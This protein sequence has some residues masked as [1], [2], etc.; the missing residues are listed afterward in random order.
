MNKVKQALNSTN[1]VR[2][3]HDLDTNLLPDKTI[4]VY[5]VAKVQHSAQT[6]SLGTESSLTLMEQSQAAF[7]ANRQ[8]RKAR[9]QLAFI[10]LG[11]S[12]SAGAMWHYST[13]SLQ[14]LA[15]TPPLPAP[16]SV[17]V[18]EDSTVAS[19]V[20]LDVA[21]T[22]LEN[23]VIVPATVQREPNLEPPAYSLSQTTNPSLLSTREIQDPVAIK[24]SA[25]NAE[26]PTPA[27]K[28]LSHKQ[29][30]APNPVVTK[31][32]SPPT[33]AKSMEESAT[34]EPLTAL[35]DATDPPEKNLALAP[36]NQ[37]PEPDAPSEAAIL[38]EEKHANITPV[39]GIP[40]I[41]VIPQQAMPLIQHTLPTPVYPVTVD[42][43]PL[44]SWDFSQDDAA[45]LS[46]DSAKPE[47]A[48]PPTQ[49]NHKTTTMTAS[50]RKTQQPT[51]N[52][53]SKEEL[54]R[55]ARTAIERGSLNETPG[56]GALYYLRLLER[57]EPNH[58]Q[59][60]ILVRDIVQQYHKQARRDLTRRENRRAA[61]QLWMASRI[62]KE[63]NLVELNKTQQIL[64][65]R[66][67]NEY[68][69]R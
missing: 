11:L 1:L 45:S 41:P 6:K 2:Q 55:R 58:P 7:T 9:Y 28:T 52:R 39:E 27:T 60:A 44:V 69:K 48:K 33:T 37:P 20:L 38:A 29:S 13:H 54:L 43:P 68:T 30:T 19:S 24:P 50:Q 67:G 65:H 47:Q 42:P 64:E 21:D 22:K 14:T 56:M 25:T 17:P 10:L 18:P 49:P 4:L 23:S 26:K 61:Q 32:T 46:T 66:L 5:E 57:L 63:F 3:T 62:I 16:V 59:I 8:L 15:P 34:M 40:V 12:I 36:M 31:L 35:A 53:M 51:A